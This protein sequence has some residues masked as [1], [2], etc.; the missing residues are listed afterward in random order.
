ML[1]GALLASA[2]TGSS[3]GDLSG[4][5]DLADLEGSRG[6]RSAD[7]A[8]PLTAKLLDGGTFS[9]AEHLA[10]D[11]RPVFLNLWASWCIPCRAEMPA[12][13]ASAAAHPEVLHLGVAVQDTL[14]NATDFA[15]ELGVGYPLAFD[16]DRS[17]DRD[18]TPVALP[19]SYFISSDGVILERIFG[20]RTTE[21]LDEKIEELF[22]S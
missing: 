3:R 2:C 22:G 8:P 21:E 13:D 4:L 6:V 1:A 10:T 12:I 19:L 14:G 17:V 16:E 15:D 11:G 5:P 18:W 9:L 20:E 7:V